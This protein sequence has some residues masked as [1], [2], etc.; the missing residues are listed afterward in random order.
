MPIKINANPAGLTMTAPTHRFT[1]V[2]LCHARHTPIHPGTD[3]HPRSLVRTRAWT[4]A[5]GLTLILVPTDDL[6]FFFKTSAASNTLRAVDTQSPGRRLCVVFDSCFFFSTGIEADGH[7]CIAVCGLQALMFVG[8]Q[9]LMFTG[10]SS[11]G[12]TELVLRTVRFLCETVGS[13]D[14]EGAKGQLLLV[15]ACM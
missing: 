11:S 7:T 2:S 8:R 9:A 4:R 14:G 3:V 12:K 15:H 1:H 5:C 10:E 13:T 6:S